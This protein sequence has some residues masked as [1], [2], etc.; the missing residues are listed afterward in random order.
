MEEERTMRS[1][2]RILVVSALIAAFSLPALWAQ[3]AAQP[4]APGPGGQF[5]SEL[6]AQ[7]KANGWAEQEVNAFAAAARQMDWSGAQA[8]NAEGV[9]LALTLQERERL[10]LSATEQ[11]QEALQLALMTAEMNAVGFSRHDCAVAAVGAARN[12]LGEIR[13]WMTGGRHGELGQIIRNRIAETVRA[14]VQVAATEQSAGN[15]T[16]SPAGAGQEGN[17]PPA[18]A[19]AGG[20]NGSPQRSGK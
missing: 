9:A 13:A 3:S 20:G 10:R 11:A 8:A 19:P 6:V 1:R 5:E 2:R 12:A 4:A 16:G 15:G 14:Q 7:L 17:G 18:W